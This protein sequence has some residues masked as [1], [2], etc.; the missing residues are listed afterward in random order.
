[1]LAAVS[2]FAS[3]QETTPTTTTSAAS[4]TSVTLEPGLYYR[5]LKIG[6]GAEV[7]SSSSVQ[8]HYRGRFANGKVFDASREKQIPT[9]FRVRVGSG[10]AVKGMERALVG[11]RLGGVRDMEIAPQFGYGPNQTGKIPGGSTLFFEVEVVDMDA[12][13][14]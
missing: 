5:D 13:A 6:A 10:D 1:M 4:G 7:T 11:M 12:A 2:T 9:P 14:N 8:V 3:A